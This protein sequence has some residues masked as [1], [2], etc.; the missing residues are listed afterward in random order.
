VSRGAVV[1][2]AKCALAAV[3]AW[4]LAD[5]VLGLP[6]PF[7]APYAAVLMIDSTVYRSVRG[8]AQQVAATASAVLVAFLTSR[9]I[10]EPA[11][12]LAVAVLVGALLGR[13]SVFGASGA[14]IAVTTVLVLT[15]SGATQGVLLVD[16]LVETALGAVIGTAVNALVLPPTYSRWA[17]SATSDLARELRS[18]LSALAGA[19]RDPDEPRD[20]RSWVERTRESERLVRR[21]EEA[22]G[23]SDEADHLNLRRPRRDRRSSGSVAERLRDAWPR[24]V[25]IAEAVHSSADAGPVTHYPTPASRA[26]YA[27]LLDALGDVVDRMGGEDFDAAVT[28]TQH[29]LKVLDERVTTDPGEPPGAARG[30]SGMLLPARQALDALTGA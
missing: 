30:L 14:W 19:L 16:R 6:Q 26:E 11:V 17:R 8:S 12:A 22:V 5:R 3:L 23:W 4:L 10:P 25:Q 7:L 21:A 9:M 13:W 28:R 24:V 2:A 1:R 27:D 18:V 29:L 15:T 20:P